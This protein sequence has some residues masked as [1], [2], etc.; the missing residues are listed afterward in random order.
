VEVTGRARVPGDRWLA[1]EFQ[2]GPSM[3]LSSL[4]AQALPSGASFRALRLDPAIDAGAI[5]DF[6]PGAHIAV[7]LIVEASA[8]LRF[9]RYSLDGA[10]I[11]SEP[12]FVM[13]SGVRLSVGVD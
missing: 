1:F 9:Q 8:L 4:S 7:G 6:T 2:G 12:N 13:V 11:L 10:P 5:V 3:V